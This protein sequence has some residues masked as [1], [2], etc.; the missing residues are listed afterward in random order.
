MHLIHQSIYIYNFI[1]NF[2]KYLQQFQE[3]CLSR[4]VE[5]VI[6]QLPTKEQLYFNELSEVVESFNIDPR[7]LDMNFPDRFLDSLS[8]KNGIKILNLRNAFES[9][10]DRVYFAYDEHLNRLGHEILATSLERFVNTHIRSHR[11]VHRISSHNTGDRYP[12][13]YGDTLLQQSIRDSNSEII[14]KSLSDKVESRLTFDDVDQIHPDLKGNKLVYTQGNQ[15][16]GETEVIY[17]DLSTNE[18]IVL[19]SGESFGAIPTFSEDGSKVVYAEWVNKG[20]LSTNPKIVLYDL[21]NG[22][23][24]ALTDDLYEHWRPILSKNDKHVFYI[25]KRDGQFDVYRKNIQNG[26]EVNL[27]NSD[28]DEWDIELSDNEENLVFASNEMGNWDLAVLNFK[29][30]K[31][32]YLTDSKGNEWDPYW[33]NDSLFFAADYGIINGIYHIRVK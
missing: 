29:T 23:K 33:T 13:V 20:D 32:K 1:N 10:K 27:T 4:G 18:L 7:D 2:S 15:D 9:S 6:V 26:N 11:G 24:R 21:S 28:Y 22:E 17:R 12:R 30:N 31:V 19:T 25:S 16:T 8:Q 5:L 14:I 3:L